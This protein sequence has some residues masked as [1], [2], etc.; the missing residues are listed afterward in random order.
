MPSPSGQKPPSSTGR[1]GH[2]PSRRGGGGGRGGGRGVNVPPSPSQLPTASPLQP[3]PAPPATRRSPSMEHKLAR[4]PR[5]DHLQASSSTQSVAV[6]VNPMPGSSNSLRP[7]ARPGFGLSGYPV[8]VKANHFLVSV[9]DLDLYRYNVFISP[10]VSS[11]KVCRVIMKQLDNSFWES[12]MGN[13]I[14][15]YD[16]RNSCYTAGKLPFNSKDI[17]VKLVDTDKIS[18]ARRECEFKVSINFA[19]K[20]DLSNL[21]QLIEGG[22]LDALHDTVQCL[23]IILRE[24]PSNDYEAIGQSFFLR[25]FSDQELGNGLEY[26][27]GFSQSLR[28]TQMGLSLNIDTSARAFYEPIYVSD[29]VCKYLNK[30]L[31]RPLSDQDRLEVK[32]AL[33]GI[34]VEIN[35]QG[36]IQRHKIVGMSTESTELTMFSLDGSDA[37]ISVVQYFLQ[38]Y[39]IMLKYP[40]LPAL[41]AGSSSKSIYFPMEVCKIVDGQFYSKKL[42]ARQVISLLEAT[43]QRPFDRENSITDMVKYNNYNAKEI[44]NTF[45]INVGPQLTSI[46]AQLLPTPRLKYHGSGLLSNVLPSVGQWS[47]I[48]R[49]GF[50]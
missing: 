18:G 19:S 7:P 31:T 33:K 42:N 34:R 11:K 25:N 43:C 49:V 27:K 44:L 46:K 2:R 38:K 50:P 20:H 14:F 30:D 37:T 23:D 15:A 48:D 29:Y 5:R 28:L 40:C 36:H 24:R 47:M 32:R 22:Q 16:G 26:W 35:H 13:K 3:T 9:A 12:T 8:V 6:A 41:Q 21:Q 17:V 10:E 1:R 45:G 39:K 4:S